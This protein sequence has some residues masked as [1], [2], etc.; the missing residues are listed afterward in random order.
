MDV[1]KITIDMVRQ[2]LTDLSIDLPRHHGFKVSRIARKMMDNNLDIVEFK[3]YYELD[4]KECISIE[5]RIRRLLNKEEDATG[6]VR[7]VSHKSN[8]HLWALVSQKQLN[9][10]TEKQAQEKA[11]ADKIKHFCAKAGIDPDDVE[12]YSSVRMPIEDF[13]KLIAYYKES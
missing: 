10:E 5:N 12:C 3:R 7:N 2:A 13:E 8:S 9:Q 1:S 11:R 6:L 4:G